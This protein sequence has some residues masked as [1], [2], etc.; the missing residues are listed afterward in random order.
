MLIAMDLSPVRTTGTIVHSTGFLPALAELLHS[1]DEVIVFSPPTLKTLL[2]SLPSKSFRSLI[3][4]R[5]QSVPG[6]LVWQQSALPQLLRRLRVDVLLSPFSIAPLRAPCP[7]VLGITTPNALA[8]ED[9]ALAGSRK[10][11]ISAL[12]HHFMSRRSCARAHS[13]VFP[14]GYAARVLGPLLGVPES[15]RRVAYHGLDAEFW[16]R[17]DEAPTN[18]LPAALEPSRY[19]LFP[20]KFYRQKRALLLLE[21]YADW[22]KRFGPNNYQLVYTGENPESAA[23][24]EV[25]RAAAR[26]GVLDHVLMLG[27]V[28]RETLLRL[29]RA[30]AAIA[31]PS[32]LETFGFPYVEA[33]ASGVPLVCA[34]IEVAR[35]LCG[36]AAWYAVPDSRENLVAVLDDALRETDERKSKVRTGVERARKFSWAREAEVTLALIREAAQSRPLLE[37]WTHKTTA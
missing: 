28:A 13:V 23:A 36:D 5:L 12:L 25:L 30:A 10:N 9:S 11:N 15:R 8:L 1:D 31:M 18:N 20:S 33:M 24:C 4:P 22:K 14:S 26:L 21:A 29:Y 2:S 34:D 19:I 16:L 32:V 17:G 27:I 35:E 6:R 3:D 37:G 7:V